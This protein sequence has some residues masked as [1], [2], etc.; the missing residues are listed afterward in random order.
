LNVLRAGEESLDKREQPSRL[1]H[2][3]KRAVAILDIDG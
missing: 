1:E 2:E 3:R